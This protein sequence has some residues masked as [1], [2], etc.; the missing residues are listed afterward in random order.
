MRVQTQHMPV[1]EAKRFELP[2]PQL[3]QSTGQSGNW[4]PTTLKG[5]MAAQDRDPAH[6]FFSR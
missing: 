3:R 1:I 4:D 6:F 2:H 5:T